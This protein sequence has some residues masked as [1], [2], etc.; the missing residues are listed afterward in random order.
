MKSAFA[1][2]AFALLWLL[3]AAALPAAQ[4]DD[5]DL[6]ARDPS[7]PAERSNV[8]IVLDS[9]ERWNAAFNAEISALRTVLESTVDARY[10]VGLMLFTGRG[11]TR[12]DNRCGPFFTMVGRGSAAGA[13]LRS[14]LLPMTPEHRERLSCILR[15]LSRSADAA[16]GPVSAAMALAEADRYLASAQTCAPTIIVYLSNGP[17]SG[18]ASDARAARQ[19]LIVAG[20]APSADGTDGRVT[21]S[22]AE[23][24][25]A[26]LLA[27][28]RAFT[29]VIDVLPDRHGDGAAWSSQLRRIAAQGHGRYTVADNPATLQ[30]DIER[31]LTQAF[32]P[33]LAM[34]SVLAPV[35]VPVSPMVR[36]SHLNEV[37]VG[38]FRP[39]DASGPGGAP[40]LQQY[41]LSV[42]ASADADVLALVASK[43]WQARD[44]RRA[45]ASRLL[46]CAGAC[47]PGTL[48]SPMDTAPRGDEAT[49]A[50]RRA[51]P[52]A[53]VHSRPAIIHYG[54]SADDT[55][56]FYGGGDG[57]LH[58]VHGGRTATAGQQRWAFALPT[59]LID[60]SPVAWTRTAAADG[61]LDARRGDQA[62]LFVTLRR[63]GRVIAALDVSNPD[64]PRMLWQRSERDP[65]F[66][67]LGQTWSTPVVA[68]IRA[69][70]GPVLIMGMG[71][72]PAASDAEPARPA[73]IGRGVMVI[74]AASG[75]L[76]WQAGPD[77][78]GAESGRV[79]SGMRHDM[80]ADVSVIDS[81]G[82]GMADRVY[83]ADTGANLWR[84][85]IDAAQPRDWR[86]QK[87]AAL[88]G[89]GIDARKFLYAPDVVLAAP[90]GD[91][92]WLLIGSGDREHPR[93]AT[94]RNRYY[95]I[96]DGHARDYFRPVVLTEADLDNR[97]QVVAAA[98]PQ[99]GWFLPLEDGEQ[100][101]GGSTTLNGAVI[102][103]SHLAQAVTAQT[104]TMP[105]EARLYAV[106]HRTATPVFDAMADGAR[107]PRDRYFSIAGGGLLPTPVPAA[108][109]VEGR[110]RTVA[111]VGTQIIEP[112]P[113]ALDQPLRRAATVRSA[114]R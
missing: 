23:Q 87:V 15:S 81:D 106:D 83:A 78:S 88:G 40:G 93:G 14:R 34:D 98:E 2:N 63:G 1:R 39:R 70:P 100:I 47:A 51:A 10:N 104:C 12:G 73:R 30:A 32:E 20:G 96:R 85:D 110:L 65:G 26:R 25:A 71:Y 13:Y 105:G 18:L 86:V 75:R 62:W 103:A 50:P 5:L 41:Q 56:L 9:S 54:P 38:Q 97:S 79:V 22:A 82:D 58:A 55:T 33:M 95:A 109:V 61:R 52:D 11:D 42:Q 57:L 49:R 21:D 80:P 6:F 27:Q 4:A 46:S 113:P 48:L 72:D 76:L 101:A 92:D 99:N 44:S 17:A 8:L 66:A 112:P 114:R 43:A 69:Q 90:G 7:V 35:T 45:D 28:R 77:V 91:S 107:A 3:I 24:W 74:D 29:Q 68:R 89:N 60:G 37:Y 102:F 111:L 84:I 19:A 108:I 36:G 64:A 31:A 16:D 94:V 67:L 59:G 53:V